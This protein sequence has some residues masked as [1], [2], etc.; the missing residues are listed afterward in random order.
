MRPPLVGR[1]YN[2]EGTIVSRGPGTM[3]VVDSA[4]IGDPYCRAAVNFWFD[5]DLI[6]LHNGVLK[7]TTEL[8]AT[9][10]PTDRLDPVRRRGSD[11]TPQRGIVGATS[12]PDATC[13]TRCQS[14][15]RI[16]RSRITASCV[17]SQHVGE[18][19]SRNGA[20]ANVWHPADKPLPLNGNLRL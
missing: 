11:G 5:T 16:R 15:K 13:S 18:A 2:L 3:L 7:D 6:I 8:T 19:A 14:H 9:R 12:A 1:H 10:D 20:P 4:L 17:V